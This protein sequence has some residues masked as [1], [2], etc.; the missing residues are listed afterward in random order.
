M[1]GSFAFQFIRQIT[2]LLKVTPEFLKIVRDDF[3]NI[4]RSPSLFVNARPQPIVARAETVQPVTGGNQRFDKSVQSE[5]TKKRLDLFIPGPDFLTDRFTRGLACKIEA[6]LSIQDGKGR[7]DSSLE[8]VFPE[9]HPA[10]TMDS[11]DR[12]SRQHGNRFRPLAWFC[13]QR[14]S[15]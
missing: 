6:T 8:S 7:I 3:L 5:I 9:K 13:I 15:D 12:R 2:D 10:K 14:R 1:S 4:T 11:R